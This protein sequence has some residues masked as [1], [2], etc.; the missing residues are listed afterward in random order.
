[1]KYVYARRYFGH[2][3][4][5]MDLAQNPW[6]QSGIHGPKVLVQNQLVQDQAVRS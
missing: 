6:S 5:S 1:M 2:K 4:G 3:F